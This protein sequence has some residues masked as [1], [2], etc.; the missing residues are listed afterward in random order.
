MFLGGFLATLE[1]VYA[2]MD[3]YWEGIIAV[4]LV[5][6]LVYVIK[7]TKAT[8]SMAKVHNEELGLKKRPIIS[9]YNRDPEVFKFRTKV[10]NLSNIHA[11]LR[12]KANVDIAGKDLK[13][14]SDQHYSGNRIWQLQG[15]GYIGGHLSFD[16]L[17]EYNDM[18]LGGHESGEAE[19]AL[20]CWVINYYDDEKGLF[21]DRNK[22]P[23]VH[24][25]WKLLD[26]GGGR[27]VPEVSPVAKDS[28]L[29]YE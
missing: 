7:Y 13:I 12:V 10:T 3:P 21:D 6:T 18:E 9:V 24:W 20:E 11:K 28:D 4:A 14:P 26:S 17:F 1:Y 25:S 15:G 8:W 19:V 5:A 2:L 27:W 29:E 22:N 16:D 23:V